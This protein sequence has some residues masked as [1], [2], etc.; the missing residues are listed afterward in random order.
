MVQFWRQL[1]HWFSIHT[2]GVVGML[3]IYSA[4]EFIERSHQYRQIICFGMGK[5]FKTA[6]ALFEGT[7]VWE[8][9]QYLVDNDETKHGI[10]III[11]KKR[12]NVI[13]LSEMAEHQLN[14]KSAVLITPNFYTDIIKQISEYEILKDL[15]MI[16]MTHILSIMS[17]REVEGE[18]IPADFRLSDKPLIPKVIHYFW[19]GGK[20]IPDK[21][22]RCIESW[23]KYCPDYTIVEWNEDNYDINQNQYMQQAYRYGKWA[24]VPDYARLDTIY[25]YGGIYL[26]TDV[27]IL[28]NMDDLLWQKGFAGFETKE[29]VA[30]GLGF[31][32]VKGMP[33]IGKMRDMYNDLI[34]ADKD[35]TL[36]LIPSPRW[37]TDLLKKY[38]LR[39][40]GEYQIV[41]DMT[42]Y[43][44]KVLN[45]KAV[46][47]CHRSNVFPKTVHHY[48]LSSWQEKRYIE[49]M[50]DLDKDMEEYYRQKN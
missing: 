9:I 7:P 28:Q 2:K 21:Y 3:K 8:K 47:K 33:I 42:I 14:G 32:A 19:F 26:D 15:D 50:T 10:E 31:G 13:T 17:E 48:E 16:C 39:T 22:Q 44:I 6:K 37:Q 25:R 11:N 18:R 43:P 30:L 23:H 46:F 45:G 49:L 27:E 40:T 24:F 36:N 35:E 41:E 4:E 20:R 34:F 29:F 5:R 12:M 1:L 38:G